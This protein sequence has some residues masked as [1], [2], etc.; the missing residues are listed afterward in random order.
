MKLIIEIKLGNDT[1]RNNQQVKESLLS[2]RVIGQTGSEDYIVGECGALR[3]CNGNVIGTWR[4]AS[5]G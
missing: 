5:R 2:S 3:D 1:M 4:V